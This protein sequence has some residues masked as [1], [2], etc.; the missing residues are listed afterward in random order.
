VQ[1]NTLNS[2]QI[3]GFTEAIGGVHIRFQ[4][5]VC[6]CGRAGGRAYARKH[7]RERE[8]VYAYVCTGV[9]V[10][11]SVSVHARAFFVCV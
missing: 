9:C 3:L 8:R 10:C 2:E 4:V 7:A 11:V 5:L 6:T 1:F